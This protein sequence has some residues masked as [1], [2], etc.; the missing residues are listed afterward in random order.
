MPLP[1]LLFIALH[2]SQAEPARFAQLASAAVVVVL[3]VVVLVV[4][5]VVN[6]V[7]LEC[8]VVNPLNAQ[9][10]QRSLKASGRN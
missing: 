7:F 2:L 8:S 9:S 6:R 5:L 3:V 1:L 4:V 10:R